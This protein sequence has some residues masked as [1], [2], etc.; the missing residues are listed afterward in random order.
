MKT[1]DFEESLRS[2][3]RLARLTFSAAAASV[4]LYSD[5]HQ[6]LIFEAA[7]GAGEDRIVGMGVPAGAGI[8]GWVA[9]T[10][11][12]TLSREVTADA[13]FNLQVAV[14]TG[15]I[16]AVVMASPL[17]KDGEIIGVMEVLDPN[18]A[19]KGDMFA[20]DMLS[21]LANQAS[22]VLSLVDHERGGESSERAHAVRD[23]DALLLR[24]PAWRADAVGQLIAALGAIVAD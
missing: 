10:G 12:P 18:L 14:E 23:F 13:R 2:T 17:I 5:D 16:P 22:M 4:F 6:M 20:L 19:G 21:E 7:S 15:Y 1:T 8:V 3:A 24:L 11:E 9:E